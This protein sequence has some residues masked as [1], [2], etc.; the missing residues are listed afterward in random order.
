M[1][2]QQ[3]EGLRGGE[4]ECGGCGASVQSVS[5]L[6]L[7]DPSATNVLR[8][9][10]AKSLASVSQ[11]LALFLGRECG[12][13][14][15]FQRRPSATRIVMLRNSVGMAAVLQPCEYHRENPIQPG[16]DLLLSELL[17]TRRRVG[18]R[19][20]IEAEKSTPAELFPVPARLMTALCT[21]KRGDMGELAVHGR[22]MCG[23]CPVSKRY[24]TD[25]VG[26]AM[27]P[28]QTLSTSL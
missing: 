11:E 18:G 8:K 3:L 14:R 22:S 5:A 28:H 13:K 1:V 27:T 26:R 25:E 21:A 12:A 16:A 19:L 15:R 10:H 17:G 6:E 9:I 20:G 4:G 23:G 7:D 24:A 2:T